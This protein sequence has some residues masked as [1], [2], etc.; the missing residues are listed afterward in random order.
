M[1]ES[2]QVSEVDQCIAIT[3]SGERCTRPARDGAFCYQHDEDS[4]TLEEA[5]D[6]DAESVEDAL[7]ERNELPEN[8]DES[9]DNETLEP[10]DIEGP[11][12]LAEI[13]QR[14]QATAD[15]I[16]GRPLDGIVS[17]RRNDE[18]WVVRVDC[19]ERKAIPDT[20]DI[21]GQYEI[22]FTEDGTVMGYSRHRRY[23][24]GDMGDEDVGGLIQENN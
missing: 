8:Q 16:I 20:Q 24:R 11:L 6:V 21:L 2:V 13:R 15:Q 23:R 17:V 3:S 4:P 12:E 10:P 14:V 9:S 22:E 7:E 5:D 18:G 1:S 19:L